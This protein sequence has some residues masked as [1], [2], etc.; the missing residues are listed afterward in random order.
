[1]RSRSALGL[2]IA[3]WLHVRAFERH[4]AAFRQ[5]ARPRR[6]AGDAALSRRTELLASQRD[7]SDGPHT[8]VAAQGAR[9]DLV[10]ARCAIT[11]PVA[12]DEPR[13]PALHGGGRMGRLEHVCLCKAN[14][15]AYVGSRPQS[16]SS[17]S[18]SSE[19]AAVCASS[20]QRLDG[21]VRGVSARVSR[22]PLIGQDNSDPQ[23]SYFRGGVGMLA[24]V[25]ALFILGSRAVGGRPGEARRFG[26][27]LVT[28]ALYQLALHGTSV[29]KILVILALNYSAAKAT[30]GTRLAQ[31]VIWS[32]NLGILFL[33][34]IYDGY[35][36]RSLSPALAF[37]VRYRCMKVLIG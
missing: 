28:A 24:V 25:G 22:P 20:V 8:G 35:Q 34:E 23:Y 10:S 11:A 36:Y 3:Q 13:V 26:Y 33:N 21:P 31:P 6:V 17:C 5:R 14:I 32:L 2:R 9:V 7:R 12:V 37:L 29:L 4:P 27:L 15:P 18:R 30:A 19:L 1:M 16:R